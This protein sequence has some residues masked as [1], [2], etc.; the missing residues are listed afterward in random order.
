VGHDVTP[1]A[2]RVTNGQQNGFVFCFGFC[3]SFFVPG[4]PVNRV[5]CV[6]AKVGAGFV[7]KPIHTIKLLNVLNKTNDFSI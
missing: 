5:V 4:P 2:S 6:L 7:L 1:V 3:E